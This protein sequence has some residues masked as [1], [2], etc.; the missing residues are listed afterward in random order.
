LA[1]VAGEHLRDSQTD[2]LEI[3]ALQRH[4]VPAV[5][6]LHQRSFPNFFLSQL[7]EGFLR[8]F[9]GGFLNDPTAVTAV[10]LDSTG[11]VRGAVV[12]TTE[13]VGFFKR[14]L[15]RR[16]FGFACRSTAFALRNPADAPRL[17]RAVGYRGDAP[18]GPGGGA[19]LSSICVD[20]TLQGGGIGRSLV[21][22]WTA[23]ASRQ[24]TTEAFLTTDAIG[25]TA[26]NRFYQGLG[27][28]ISDSYET[29]EGRRMHRY[30][31]TLPVHAAERT[32]HNG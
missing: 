32:D 22:A 15:K 13:P 24:G 11:K 17:L 18:E 1:T 5:A 30:V 16:L 28:T 23:T 7:G 21:D 8:E 31:T 2:D 20:P 26:V 29:P 9:Y 19:L 14:L 10:A 27:W 12:G 25:N 6:A 4:H 3:V